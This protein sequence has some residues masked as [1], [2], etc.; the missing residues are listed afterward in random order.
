MSEKTLGRSGN[1]PRIPHF[2]FL[3]SSILP[4]ADELLELR[5]G[6]WWEVIE[7]VKV[8]ELW[9]RS[10]MWSVDLSEVTAKRALFGE[11]AIENMIA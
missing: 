9:G 7:P 4:D 5:W 10:K 8:G 1:L 2:W 11:M 6:R 3:P